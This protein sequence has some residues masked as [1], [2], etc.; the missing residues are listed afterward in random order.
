MSP[1]LSQ[2]GGLVLTGLPQVWPGS[3]LP[4]PLAPPGDTCLALP[5]AQ[6]A[7]S[8]EALTSQLPRG[9]IPRRREV[10]AFG[11]SGEGL[12]ADAARCPMLGGLADL[13]GHQ[14]S[15]AL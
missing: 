11:L 2:E 5:C 14:V 1:G 13:P 6:R 15:P 10:G 8:L 3:G 4:E 12:G 7:L 9:H